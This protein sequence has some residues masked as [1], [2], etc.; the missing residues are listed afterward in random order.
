[1]YLSIERI[2]RVFRAFSPNQFQPA[3]AIAV[4]LSEPHLL[5][6][7]H[8]AEGFCVGESK[9]GPRVRPSTMWDVVACSRLVILL[10][11]EFQRGLRTQL[12]SNFA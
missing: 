3:A 7:C 2:P 10:P 6:V 5:C 12:G 4:L 1:M 11:T 8:D 9:P